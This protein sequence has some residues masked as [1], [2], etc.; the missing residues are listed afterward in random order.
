MQRGLDMHLAG[1]L[2]SSSQLVAQITCQNCSARYVV[3]E[4]RIIGKQLRVTCKW[5]GNSFVLR[6]D[7]V[8]AAST[9]SSDLPVISEI[10]PPTPTP[11]LHSNRSGEL[12][13]QMRTRGPADSRKAISPPTPTLLST[14]PAALGPEPKAQERAVNVQLVSRRS[15]TKSESATAG[16]HAVPGTLVSGGKRRASTDGL[17]KL[18]VYRGEDSAPSFRDPKFQVP[19]AEL[20]REAGVEGHAQVEKS[21]AT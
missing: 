21:P 6:G 9:P 1:R 5:C 12:V 13:A 14:Q 19:A 7:E 16:V 4:H 17:P 11:I 2:R 18:G 3:P 20:W 8:I 15:E 10:A